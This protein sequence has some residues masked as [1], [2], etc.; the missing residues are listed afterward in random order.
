MKPTKLFL[1][2]FLLSFATMANAQVKVTNILGVSP[3]LTHTFNASNSPFSLVLDRNYLVDNSDYVYYNK[4]IKAPDFTSYQIPI[5][6]SKEQSN[7]FFIN[8]TAG[9]GQDY[10]SST[11]TY[12]ATDITDFSSEYQYIKEE[13]D[14]YNIFGQL[15]IGKAIYFL[16]EK[17]LMVMP[18]LGGF[19]GLYEYERVLSSDDKFL[20]FN[21]SESSAGYKSIAGINLG[22]SINYQMTKHFGLG[23]NF[24][25]IVRFYKLELKK[26]YTIGEPQKSSQME[27]N[28]NFTPRI[29]L[30]YY[31]KSK[32]G[33]FY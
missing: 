33:I 25:D 7:N 14:A 11:L 23:L 10:Y 32:A 21:N 18:C 5:R 3:S 17:K 20:F 28:L 31:F 19:W 9:F 30:L 29:S 27:L 1:L 24:N 4:L 13:V 6:F 15:S 2:I 16:P 22:L 26:E 8:F 12:K